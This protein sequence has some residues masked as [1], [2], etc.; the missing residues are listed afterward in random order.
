MILG[1]C[2]QKLIDIHCQAQPAAFIDIERHK[3]LLTFIH[4]FGLLLKRQKQVLFQTPVHKST[5]F[6][7]LCYGQHRRLPKLNFRLLYRRDQPVLGILI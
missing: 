4:F 3:A 2:A 1:I 5:D 7:N 6:P